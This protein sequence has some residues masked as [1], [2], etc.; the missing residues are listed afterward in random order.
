[1]MLVLLVLE[2]QLTPDRGRNLRI[3]GLLK[4]ALV[5]LVALAEDVFLEAIDSYKG[6]LANNNKKIKWYGFA[7]SCRGSPPSPHPCGRHQGPR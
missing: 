7:Y 3:L 1:M 6:G 4:R 5:A 2:V